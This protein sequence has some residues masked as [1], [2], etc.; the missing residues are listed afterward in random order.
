MLDRMSLILPGWQERSPADMMTALVEAIA[1]TADHLSY[2]QD[3]VATEAYL[4]TARKRVSVKRHARLLDYHMHDGCN[5]RAWVQVWW[6]GCSGTLPGPAQ[7]DA[8]ILHGGTKLLTQAGKMPPL[9]PQSR[10]DEALSFRP[11]VFETM[12]DITLYHAHRQ[13]AFYTWGDTNCCLRRGATRA[14]LDGEYPAL[15]KGDVLILAELSNPANGGPPDPAHRH[16]VRLT[17]DANILED[18]LVII[19]D[20][21]GAGNPKKIT[22]IEWGPEDAL[23]FPLCI[24]VTG[25]EGVPNNARVSVALGNIV[26]ADHGMSVPAGLRPDEKRPLEDLGTVPEEGCGVFSPVLRHGPLTQQGFVRK[27]NSRT[28]ERELYPADGPARDAFRWEMKDVRP[29]VRLYEQRTDKETGVWWEPV[30]DLLA[31]DQFEREFVVETEEDNAARI[32]F[33]NDENGRYPAEKH[34]FCA[35]Y[36]IGNG[37]QGNIGHDTIAHII[38]SDNLVTKAPAFVTNP[39]AASGGRDPEP[40]ETVRQDA[41]Q[42]FRTQERAVTTD[43]YAIMAGRHPEVQKAFATRRWTGSWYTFYIA[44]DRWQGKPVDRAFQDEMLL[45]LDKYRLAGHDLEVVPPLFVPLDI[46]LQV[47]ILPEYIATNVLKRL[48]AVFGSQTLPDG[49]RGFFHPDNYTFGKPVY[50]SEIIAA[51]MQVPGVRWADVPVLKRW[52]DPGP[53]RNEFIGIQEDE[54]ARLDNDPGNIQNGR[55]VITVEGGL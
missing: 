47:C 36:R 51:A 28:E 46:R 26:L 48:L 49:T 34:T 8:P 53:G 41:P 52:D 2:Y 6:E 21:N 39:L 20:N 55:I 31:S 43:D 4:G 29:A 10:L 7:P 17:S 15:K 40:R 16:A 27:K 54:I 11:V 9:I 1:Y 37:V 33:G 12:H 22:A 14:V 24:S 30:R 18:K 50:A 38:L 3:A 25:K 35:L 5:A 32:R 45:F 13:M 23:P 42:A 44:V 19:K